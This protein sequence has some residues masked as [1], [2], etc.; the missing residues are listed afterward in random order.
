MEG[1][2]IIII[3][4]LVTEHGLWIFPIRGR[5]STVEEAK[6]PIAPWKSRASVDLTLKGT[7][8]AWGLWL[9][10]SGLFG[11]DVDARKAPK[12]V[13]PL[14]PELDNGV[15]GLGGY[16][17]ETATGGR[18]YIF[19]TSN[20]VSLSSDAD[21][22]EYKYDGYFIIAPS[23]LLAD[24][25]VYRYR[26]ICGGLPPEADIS[27]V[28]KAL[29]EIFKVVLNQ[30]VKIHIGSSGQ[31]RAVPARQRQVFPRPPTYRIKRI[32]EKAGGD[33]LKASSMLFAEVGCHG[34]SEALEGVLRG[35][36]VP[37]R[38]IMVDF[39]R[40][41]RTSRFLFLHI[42][43]ASLRILG[44]DEERAREALTR[45]TF[46]DSDEDPVKDSLQN[47]IDN[48]YRYSVFRIMPVGSCPFCDLMGREP[49]Q[50]RDPNL[51][52]GKIG[53]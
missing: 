23:V 41:S 33:P 12:E 29:E 16:A 5:G 15:C 38:K 22:I 1:D 3:R 42:V 28:S 46:I 7:Y 31:A 24:G 2:A 18:H 13:I 48:V 27:S 35:E 10:R 26:R 44:I 47:A 30:K 8:T 51:L 50:Y 49:C 19:R 36:K 37:I 17:E 32:I 21:W 11:I 45:I 39:M 25:R 43:A 40:I 4:R 14:L 20:P 53:I 34:I 6:Q 9:S 52:L